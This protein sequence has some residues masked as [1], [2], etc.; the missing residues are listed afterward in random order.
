MHSY[1]GVLCLLL[2]ASCL[3]FAG[4]YLVYVFGIIRAAK[5]I[6]AQLIEECCRMSARLSLQ[7]VCVIGVS[8]SAVTD[9]TLPGAAGLLQTS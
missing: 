3:T 1:L 8:E 2:L 6:H 7:F 4:G 5:K 9:A